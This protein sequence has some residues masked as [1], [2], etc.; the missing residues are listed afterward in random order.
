MEFRVAGRVNLVAEGRAVTANYVWR[1]FPDGTEIDLWG[2][3]GQGRTRVLSEGDAFAVHTADGTRLDGGAARALVRREFGLAAP[4]ALLSNWMLGRPAPGWPAQGEENG[5]FLQLGWRVAPS[6]FEEVSGRR[7]PARLVAT[8]HDRRL[9][10][11][12][13]EWRFPGAN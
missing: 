12:C 7:V 3:L 13:R 5:A 9:T 2:P 11:L 1:Q 10:V 6:G 4:V 8:R